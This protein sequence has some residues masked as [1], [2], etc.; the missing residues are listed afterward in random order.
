MLPRIK[1]IGIFASTDPVAVDSACWDAAAKAGKR[2]K[3]VEQL[4]YAES[5]GLGSRKYT[6]I[7]L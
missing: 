2:F 5:L 7:Q 4:A 6:L 3:G 1:D